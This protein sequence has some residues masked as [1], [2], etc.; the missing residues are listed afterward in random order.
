MNKKEPAN[1]IISTRQIA[2]R[3]FLNM[4]GL[5]VA[6]ASLFPWE[7]IKANISSS[8]PAKIA[9]QLYTVRNQIKEN[10]TDT[11]HRVADFGFEAVETAFWPENISVKQAGKYLKDAGLSV[12]SAHIELPV[13]D[14]K[15]KA[16]LEVAEVFNCKKLIWHGWPEDKRYSSPEGTKAL[17]DIYNETNHFAK[18]NGL[19]FGLHN[20]WWEYRNKVDGRYVYE[21]LKES[22]EPDI[23]FEIDTYWVK[24]A[25]HDPAEIVALFGKRAPLLHIKDGPA[26][27]NDS[28]PLDNPD[29]MVAVGQGT[30]NFPAIVKAANGNT[31]W[32][33]VEMDKT[34]TDVFAAIGDSYN[35]LVKNKLARGKKTVS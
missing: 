21:V 22:V 10:I 5:A 24:V 6:G 35:Y 2:R 15:K 25:G 29:P 34:A 30:Q 31:E 32:M 17:I 8:Q 26:K 4:T 33:I 12:C 9:L 16:M 20:H 27:W 28:L 18:S 3:E 14:E 1:S 19:Q 13:D 23:F 11:L 7:N